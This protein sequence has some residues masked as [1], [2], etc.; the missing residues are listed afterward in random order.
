MF[1]PGGLISTCV[2]ARAVHSCLTDSIDDTFVLAEER[3]HVTQF[4]HC[5]FGWC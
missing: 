2:G 4:V 3:K 5:M 1:I